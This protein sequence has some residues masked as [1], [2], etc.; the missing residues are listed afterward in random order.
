MR[1]LYCQMK[2]D[3]SVNLKLCFNPETGGDFFILHAAQYSNRSI[4][5]VLLSRLVPFSF[6]NSLIQKHLNCMSLINLK[7]L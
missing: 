2:I 4:I 7:R 5:F 3:N 1:I 6:S